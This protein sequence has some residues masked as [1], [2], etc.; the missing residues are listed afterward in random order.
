MRGIIVLAALAL[1]AWWLWP[2]PSIEPAKPKTWVNRKDGSEMIWIPAGSF[3]MGS[4]DMEYDERP[5]HRVFLRGYWIGKYPVTNRQFAAFLNAR[6]D[7]GKTDFSFLRRAYDYG[8]KKEADRFVVAA[9]KET[10][11]AGAIT[12]AGARAYCK[13]AGLRLPT[14]AEWEKAARGDDGRQYPWGSEWKRGFETCAEELGVTKDNVNQ[15][16]L[17]A[18]PTT[19]VLSHPQNVSPYGCIDMAGNVW[20]WSSSL[21]MAYPYHADD[22]R[23]NTRNKGIARVLRGGAWYLPAMFSRTSNR[24]RAQREVRHQ[25]G[26]VGFRVARSENG[27]RE[28][29]VSVKNPVRYN[30]MELHAK[31]LTFSH[32]DDLKYRLKKDGTYQPGTIV[33]YPV[34][35]ERADRYPEPWERLMETLLR[36]RLDGFAKVIDKIEVK[37]DDEVADIGAGSGFYTYL[38]A[39]KT[40]GKVWA[41]D[42]AVSTLQF[43]Q[44]RLKQEPLPNLYL[45]LHEVTDVLLAPATIDLALVLNLHYFYFPRARHHDSPPLSR[46]LSFYR[47]IHRA[48]KARGRMV[49]LESSDE[50]PV[51]SPANGNLTTAEMKEQLTRAGFA[52]EKWQRLT[53]YAERN[54]RRV[55]VS[56]CDLFIF[57]KKK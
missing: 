2:R 34:T 18:V 37:P 15:M 53:H 47:S 40:H 46:V 13:W 48:L 31:E 12:Y 21:Y 49:V 41:T 55:I 26:A 9:G 20:E 39:R 19:S 17:H 1:T 44:Q 32:A 11:P 45:V 22:G 29:S 35:A 10:M 38:F 42:I 3:T 33:G 56:S 43:L 25:W 28:P 7:Q 36:R 6:L 51:Q 24:Y 16:G 52:C 14:E 57:V 27:L 8:I 23:E 54:G 30:K 4:D 50:S 5:A